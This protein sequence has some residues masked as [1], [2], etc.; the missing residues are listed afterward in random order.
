MSQTLQP[1][2][3]SMKPPTYVH[4]GSLWQRLLHGVRR[5]YARHDWPRYVG[6]DWPDRIM[7]AKATDD[8]HEKQG[9]STGRFV[10]EAN[11]TQLV[12]YL[13][14]H[15]R[16]PLKDGIA[17]MLWPRGDWS[18]G[19]QE[20]R[21]LE[22]ARSQGLPVPTIVAAGEYVGSWGKLQSFLAIE[23]LTNM[24][25]LHEAIP[26]A[27]RRLDPISFRRWKAGLTRE[28]ARLSRCLHDRSAFHKDLYLCHFFIARADVANAPDWHGRVFM[29][30]F[31]RFARHHLAKTFWLSKDL[32]QLLYSSEIDGIDAR[33]RLRFWRA[34][35]GHGRKTWFGRWLKRIVLMRLRRYR[36]HNTKRTK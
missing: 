30:D 4:P 11:G 7:H 33:D 8:F 29:I 16:L 15:Y 27:A 19:M 10:F 31:H 13:K 34:Y 36:D 25:P 35:L 28:I 24:L 1:T 20:R 32:G 17:A 12:V 5:L 2:A 23:E 6:A 14:R 3:P 26:L 21:N 18:P 9:R 22:W